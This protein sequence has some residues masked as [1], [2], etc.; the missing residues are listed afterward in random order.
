[1]RYHDNALCVNRNHAMFLHYLHFGNIFARVFHSA[2]KCFF[3]SCYLNIKKGGGAMKISYL[4]IFFIIPVLRGHGW[5]LY[6]Y[7]SNA[8]QRKIHYAIQHLT[9]LFYLKTFQEYASSPPFFVIKT[10]RNKN[11]IKVLIFNIL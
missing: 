8:K 7:T 9:H 11:N 3:N 6:L 1:M 5:K 10:V 4:I 2:L